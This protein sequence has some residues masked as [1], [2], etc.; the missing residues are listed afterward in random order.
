MERLA[1]TTQLELPA[2]LN[3]I[4][5]D[6]RRFYVGAATVL[7][8]L[9]SLWAFGLGGRT[10]HDAK[11]H[12]VLNLVGAPGVHVP[13]LGVPAGPT[14]IALSCVCVLAGVA[15]MAMP[16]PRTWR[17]VGTATY[18]VCFVAAFLVWA[19]AHNSLNVAGLLQATVVAAV[20]LIL[21]ALS[22]VLC[23]RSGVINVAIEGQF[24]FGACASAYFASVLGNLWIGLLAG[25][26]A[27]AL[28][29]GILALFA[30]RYKANQVV[31]GVVLILFAQGLTGFF[32]ERL[33]QPYAN[34]ENKALQFGNIKIPGLVD[35]PVIGPVLF[36]DNV[37]VYMTIALIAGVH[38][39]LFH[40]RWGLRTRA[41]GEHPAAADTVGIR[42][43]AT[44]NR[45]VLI[46]GLIS[47]LGGVW[48]TLGQDIPFTE[49][50]S[51]GKG[52][53]A[54]AALIFGRWRPT[55]ALYAALL[56]GFAAGVS[57]SVQPL[58][59]PVPTDFFTMAPY[60]ATIFAVAG[61]IGHV[62][63]PAA[64]GMPYEP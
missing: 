4:D 49:N 56:F 32:Y 20:P 31:I 36:D 59:T 45:N 14:A 52:F 28:L 64:D 41:V 18:L 12:F 30:N 15:R 2:S 27:G 46:G 1:M 34:T 61:L 3:V 5:R 24:L 39:A 47:G 57:I 55:G 51:S 21:G 22:G 42:V 43:L 60:L 17:N 29:A 13:N 50:M 6:Q 58:N 35:I 40:T 44:R 38:V 11:A 53:I 48:L 23:E 19:T 26:L 7:A 33:L 8:G 62:R 16:L 54:L 63:A 10:R 25:C 9:F 37:I